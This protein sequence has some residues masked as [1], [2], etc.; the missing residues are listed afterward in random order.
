MPRIFAIGDIHGCNQTFR[1]LLLDEI[2]I[3]KSDKIYCL[4]DYI[5]RGPDS[6]GVIDFIL[7]LRKSGYQIYTLRGNHEE[8]MMMSSESAENFEL[9]DLNGGAAT[10]KSF[11]AK[12][13]SDIDPVYLDF[14]EATEYFLLKDKFIFVH[15]GLD[16][17][18]AD[19]FENIESMM[20]I[21]DFHIDNKKLGDRIIIH[22]HSPRPADFI[23]T[24]KE[25]NVINL[26]G[27]CV[28]S[29]R[30]GFG[31]LFALEVQSREFISIKNT[32][33]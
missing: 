3:K 20:W 16:F 4:G 28:Y 31:Y 6:K 17:S 25:S 32:D 33:F 14:F 5:D 18:I 2:R 27:G 21:R 30:P 23:P 10:L 13:Y 9:W 26:D 8:L 7:E 15:A 29:W 22:G 12:S 19:P 1:T 11:H 24:Q